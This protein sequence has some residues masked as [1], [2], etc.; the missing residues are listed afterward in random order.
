MEKATRKQQI[1]MLSR[2]IARRCTEE[3]FEFAFDDTMSRTLM[4]NFARK[5]AKEYLQK[6]DVYEDTNIN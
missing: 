2:I 4:M 1:E 5:I 6:L 3:G